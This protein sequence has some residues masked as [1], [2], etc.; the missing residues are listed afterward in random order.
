MQPTLSILADGTVAYQGASGK[1][2]IKTSF[3]N[4][5]LYSAM[6]HTITTRFDS[7][8]PGW[9]VFFY[10]GVPVASQSIHV[11]PAWKPFTDVLMNYGFYANDLATSAG[12]WYPSGTLGLQYF[13]S[14]GRRIAYNGANVIERLETVGTPL[15]LSSLPTLRIG[16]L[17]TH[18]A[19][20]SFSGRMFDFIV[21]RPRL[22]TDGITC[23]LNNDSSL[24]DTAL[25]N[26]CRCANGFYG[27]PPNCLACGMNQASLITGTYDRTCV[28]AAGFSG[29]PGNC[30]LCQIGTFCP[31]NSATASACPTGTTTTAKGSTSWYDCSVKTEWI[32]SAVF[33]VKQQISGYTGLIFRLRRSSDSAL[34]DLFLGIYMNWD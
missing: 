8:T 26:T 27:R 4:F 13:G 21:Y 2:L 18:D 33:S 31:V 25:I 1:E 29:T 6:P 22:I 17:M 19:G 9:D 24:S 11:H 32:P 28:C 23:G 34:A 30:A 12:V 3:T 10:I 14:T 20:M 5:R 16:G 7:L 15:N